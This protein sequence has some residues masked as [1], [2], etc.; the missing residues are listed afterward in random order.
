MKKVD[1]NPRCGVETM[2][3]KKN[4]IAC[5]IFE[6]EL[7]SLLSLNQ[8]LRVHWIDAALHADS[9]RMKQELDSVIGTVT[10]DLGKLCFLFGSGCHPDMSSITESCGAKLPTGKNCIHLLVGPERTKQL[11]ENRTMVITPGWLK[12]WPAIMEGLGWDEVD[13]RIN[14][15]IYDRIVLLDPGIITISDEE[16]LEFYELVQVPIEIEE[17]NLIYFRKVIEQLLGELNREIS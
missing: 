5:K 2:K 15:G 7:G 4:L 6:D 3:E 8:D 16:I 13:V 1:E 9:D 14:I 11:E 17:I 12:A 10:G